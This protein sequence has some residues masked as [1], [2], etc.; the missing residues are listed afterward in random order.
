M[1]AVDPLRPVHLIVQD[2]KAIPEDQFS[3]EL[4][5]SF[6]RAILQEEPEALLALSLAYCVFRGT[7]LKGATLADMVEVM[8]ECGPTNP[9]RGEAE[10][11]LH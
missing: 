4:G 7:K 10:G 5:R 9:A 3:L 2:L 11:G 8:I 6:A 1:Y